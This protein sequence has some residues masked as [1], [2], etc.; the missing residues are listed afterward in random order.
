MPPWPTI[1]AT[2][3]VAALFAVHACGG[4]DSAEMTPVATQP[5]PSSTPT[6][7]ARA[8]LLQSGEAME[9]LGSF[10]FQLSHESGGTTLL[11]G[12][13]IK[14]AEGLVVK[15]DKISAEFSGAF[16]GFAIKAGLITLGEDSYMTNP[17]T[18]KWE[19][20]PRQVSPLGF[21]DPSKGIAAMMSRVTGATVS[22]GEGDVYTVL[23]SLPAEAM[24]SLLGATVEGASVSVE[25]VV[26]AKALYLLKATVDGRVTAAE[27]DGTIR[28]IKLSRFN[29]D[30]TIEAPE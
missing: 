30:F 1:L 26:D 5:S 25:L 24:A 9:A 22:P 18:G 3:L 2:A 7:D 12:L 21:F 8:L 17:L 19:S 14:E 16:S 29:E 6:V 10:R 15:P 20:V 28:V 27:P 23:G 13:V 4:S 11:P